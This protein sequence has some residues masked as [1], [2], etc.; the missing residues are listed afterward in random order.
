M[1]KEELQALAQRNRTKAQSFLILYQ[2]HLYYHKKEYKQMLLHPRY[3]LKM[4]KLL[5]LAIS[6]MLWVIDYSKEQEQ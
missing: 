2:A 5:R 3:W 1:N 4:Y 6:N